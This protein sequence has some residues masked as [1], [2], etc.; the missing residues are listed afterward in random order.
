MTL[1]AWL[2]ELKDA[3]AKATKGPWKPIWED[4]QY[5]GGMSREAKEV[6]GPEFFDDTTNDHNT[7][8]EVTHSGNLRFIALARNEMARLVCIVEAAEIFK[9][10]NDRFIEHRYGGN[11]VLSCTDCRMLG[12]T[13]CTI[14]GGKDL[15]EYA[16]VAK[17][18]LFVAL[19]GEDKQTS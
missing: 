14:N 2:Q 10:A 9:I 12:V 7:V 16:I 18:I 6:F 19:R 4:V 13:N 5:A 17:K 15:N 8:A 11:G 3:E 1:P